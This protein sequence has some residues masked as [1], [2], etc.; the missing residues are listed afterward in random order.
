MYTIDTA[1]MQSRY[2][3]S[4]CSIH[5]SIALIPAY[6]VLV[7]LLIALIYLRTHLLRWANSTLPYI[8]HS[9]SCADQVL[10]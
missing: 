4:V 10:C 5:A 8:E 7:L 1:H 9:V 2:H 3:V 6:T